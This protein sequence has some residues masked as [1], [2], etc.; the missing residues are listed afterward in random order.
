MGAVMRSTHLICAT[1]GGLPRERQGI[2]SPDD[3]RLSALR[4]EAQYAH[5]GRC[6]CCFV[7][8]HLTN[9]L[10]EPNPYAMLDRPAARRKT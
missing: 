9:N 5:R 4:A 6:V 3:F 2:G 8:V 10:E 1:S 7:G